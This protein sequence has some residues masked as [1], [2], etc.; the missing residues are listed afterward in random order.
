MLTD[1]QKHALTIA[2][3]E[4]IRVNLTP[5][6][7]QL[8]VARQTELDQL[9]E[10]TLDQTGKLLADIFDEPQQETEENDGSTS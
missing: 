10:S 3:N 4:Q 1:A 5:E 6:Q 8:L 9:I 7:E 2:F